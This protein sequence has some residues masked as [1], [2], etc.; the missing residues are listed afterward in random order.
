MRVLTSARSH[1]TIA[2]KIGKFAR[3]RDACY[4]YVIGPGQGQTRILGYMTQTTYRTLPQSVILYG[5]EM[6]ESGK[7]PRF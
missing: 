7:A 2:E 6:K 5:I 1:E 3:G 4:R